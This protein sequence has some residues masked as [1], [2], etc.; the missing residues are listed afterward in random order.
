[1][2]YSLPCE[3]VEDLLPSYAEGLTGSSTTESVAAHLETCGTCR[4]KYRRMTAPEENAGAAADP[5]GQKELDF[6]KKNRTHTRKRVLLSILLSLL[7]VALIAVGW[8]YLVPKDCPA[9]LI[10]YQVHAAKGRVTFTCSMLAHG[11]GVASVEWEESAIDGSEKGDLY[12]EVCSAGLSPIHEN[13]AEVYI[14]PSIDVRSIY[15]NGSTLIWSE[16]EAILPEIDEIYECRN[17]YVGDASADEELVWKLGLDAY[18]GS[19]TLELQTASEPYGLTLISD[20]VFTA[21]QAERLEE[22]LPDYGVLLLALID[23]LGTAEFRYSAEGKTNAISV[24]AAAADE[25]LGQSVKNCVSN[26]ADLQRLVRRLDM[27]A[28]LLTPGLSEDDIGTR[29]RFGF[30]VAADDSISDL[31]LAVLADGEVCFETFCCNAD[32]TP[33]TT[34]ELMEFEFTREELAED[35]EGASAVSFVL[36]V[37]GTDGSE[38]AVDVPSS[39]PEDPAQWE[40]GTCSEMFFLSGSADIGYTLE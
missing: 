12:I 18:L 5:E 4:E 29:C 9:Q 35:L 27:T 38:T 20:E 14:E 15:L 3:I 7:A 26:A 34:G 8:R 16:G 6:L 10:S 11:R 39:L 13:Y 33:L 37:T 19:L 1:M 22:V 23:N 40:Q 31:G 2:K 30:M 25:L 32:G 24:D 17:A 28:E 36:T 21:A